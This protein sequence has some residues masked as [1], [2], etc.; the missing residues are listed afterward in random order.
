[1]TALL[2][3]LGPGERL[4]FPFGEYWLFYAL[5]GALVVA[6]LWLDLFVF[7]R[8]PRAVSMRA[9]AGWTVFWIAL[10]CVF[11]ACLHAY[12]AGRFAGAAPDELRRLYGTANP[13]KDITLEFFTGYVVEKSLSI[14]NMFV[15]VVIFGFFQ[16]PSALHHRVLFYG[17]LGALVFR[18]IFVAI[19]AALIQYTWVVW[20]FGVFLVLTGIKLLFAAE[21]EKDPER[22]W[23]LRALRRMMPLTSAF[24]GDRFLVREDVEAGGRRVRRW[25][26]T[27]LFVALVMIEFSDIIFAVDSVPAVFAVTDEPFIVFTSNIFAIMG[28]RSLYFLLAGAADRFHLLKYGLGVVLVF[29]GCKMVVPERAYPAEWEGHF[30]VSWSLG[31]ILGTIGVSMVASLFVKP[32]SHA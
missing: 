6:L 23:V 28:L 3:T 7:H 19:G 27:P 32:K 25:A 4:V 21:K 8:H 29:V 12:L 14:D 13:A 10:S 5:F 30:P 26:G 24:H 22:N 2:A 16:V 31:I 1:V 20:I 15:F 18:A 9:A 11:G 17:I